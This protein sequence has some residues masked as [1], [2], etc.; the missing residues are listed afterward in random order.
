[1]YLH[2][3]NFAQWNSRVATGAAR[4]ATHYQRDRS[5]IGLFGLAP[6]RL[7]WKERIVFE[8]KGTGGAPGAVG[9]QVAF[10]AAILSIAT[11][12]TWSGR[13]TILTNR[14]WREIRLDAAMLDDLWR[15]SERLEALTRTDRVPAATRID[16]CATCSLA[17]FCGFD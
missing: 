4:Q 7:D 1:M 12:Q 10:Y 15:D 9:R 16:L 3:I 2:R 14:R 13:V 11:S 5:T 8:N 17:S 6:D